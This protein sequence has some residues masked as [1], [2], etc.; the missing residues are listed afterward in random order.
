MIMM[1][2]LLE[3]T[4]TVITLHASF[5]LTGELEQLKASMDDDIAKVKFQLSEMEAHTHMLETENKQLK[6]EI[7]LMSGDVDSTSTTTKSA[8]SNVN[9]RRPVT[10]DMVDDDNVSIASSVPYNHSRQQLN[11]TNR[12]QLPPTMIVNKAGMNN[13]SRISM[14]TSS[15]SLHQQGQSQ[16]GGG[17]HSSVQDDPE[18]LLSESQRKNL[19]DDVSTNFL[20]LCS[21]HNLDDSLTTIVRAIDNIYLSLDLS[22][23]LCIHLPIY[24]NYVIYRHLYYHYSTPVFV[25]LSLISFLY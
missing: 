9:I 5:S 19:I 25:V 10:L 14:S 23:H 13:N 22:I 16:G 6:H 15:G 11:S 1:M 7:T 21:E 8:A 2:I 24:I 12:Q 20:A 3:G 17:P 4:I 18:R